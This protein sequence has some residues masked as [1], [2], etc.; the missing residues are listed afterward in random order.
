[1][2]WR[3]YNYRNS[4]NAQS[5]MLGKLPMVDADRNR[6]YLLEKTQHF[7]GG[8]G[9]GVGELPGELDILSVLP[10]SDSFCEQTSCILILGW[11]H[12]PSKMNKGWT[13][14]TLRFVLHIGRSNTCT[15]CR[16]G[17]KWNNTPSLDPI[18]NQYTL[19]ISLQ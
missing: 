5:Q 2:L 13:V 17:R 6:Q 11:S 12:S 1:M 9:K 18:E 19:I 16:G 14:L 15:L 7:V 10:W 8:F 3:N 4:A